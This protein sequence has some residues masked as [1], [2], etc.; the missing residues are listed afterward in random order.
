MTLD[1]AA[2]M[3]VPA[4]PRVESS[5]VALTAASALAATWTA[6]GRSGGG[7]PPVADVLPGRPCPPVP[8]S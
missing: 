1:S 7:A 3:M 2:P 8:R 5:A 6:E 4:T